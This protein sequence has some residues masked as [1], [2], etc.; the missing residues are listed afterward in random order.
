MLEGL[1]HDDGTW[2]RCGEAHAGEPHAEQRA[3]PLVEESIDAFAAPDRDGLCDIGGGIARA[4][5][6]VGELRVCGRSGGR[7]LEAVDVLRGEVQCVLQ[8]A[9]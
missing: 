1:L 4:D 2:R 5:E 9:E 8:A 3:A 7:W 6:R